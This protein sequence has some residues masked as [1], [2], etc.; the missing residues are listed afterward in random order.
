MGCY[1]CAEVCNLVGLYLLNDLSNLIGKNNAGLYRDDG[2]AVVDNASGPQM[3]KI[4]KQIHE[5]FKMHD[6]SI[7][8]EI[9]LSAAGFLDVSI[10]LSQNTYSPFRKPGNNPCTSIPNQLILLPLLSNYRL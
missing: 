2:L 5:I 10:N 6:L 7:T 1:D 8:T 9:N 3:D 4:R